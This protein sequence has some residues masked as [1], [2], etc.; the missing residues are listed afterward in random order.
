[1]SDQ[2][3]MT[4]RMDAGLHDAIKSF[5]TATETSVNSVVQRACADFV[6]S[7]GRR[8][9]VETFFHRAMAQFGTA[10]DKLPD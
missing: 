9:T 4:V 7:P 3:A 8:E 2:V 10:V 5:A 6:A 1:M